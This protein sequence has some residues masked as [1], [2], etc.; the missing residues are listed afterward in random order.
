[1]TIVRAFDDLDD[2]TLNNEYEP[3]DDPDDE[4]LPLL[5]LPYRYDEWTPVAALIP[6]HANKIRRNSG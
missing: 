2:E 1:M 5:R 4:T 6:R 3:P